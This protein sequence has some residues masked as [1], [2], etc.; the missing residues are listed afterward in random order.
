M[1]SI[2]KY[3]VNIMYCQKQDQRQKIRLETH[4]NILKYT[5]GW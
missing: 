5:Y 2:E 1:F 4:L 3:V